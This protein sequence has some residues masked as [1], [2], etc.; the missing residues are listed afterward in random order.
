MKRAIFSSYCLALFSIVAMTQTTNSASTTAPQKA[1]PAAWNMLKFARETSQTL[2]AN[3]AGVTA[4]V[5]LNNNGKI[6]KGSINYEVGKSVEL[7]I[8]GLDEE[9]KG[10]LN[11]QTMSIIAH[12]RGGDFS[13]GD[14][15]HPITFA[16]DD[17]S[18]AG[19]RI[20]LN[21]PMKSHYRVRNN[22][23]VEVDRTMGS[24]HFIITVLE[25][26]RTPEGKNLPRHFTVTYFDPQSGAVKRTETFT[27]EYKLIN[28][29]W[30]P[31]SRR[32]FR[33]E[34]GKVVTRIIEFHNPRIRFN[35]EQ[36]AR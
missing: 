5:V 30:F 19:R 25:T 4:D 13:K 34:N 7:K 20:A 31:A 10:W 18:P 36:A 29:V 21:D 28:G 3:F 15:R 9:T 24:D 22:Q 1:N 35:N 2:P 17:N 23:V 12:R 6:S 11:D 14:G 32:I 33:A 16:E 26:T 27:D 8:E